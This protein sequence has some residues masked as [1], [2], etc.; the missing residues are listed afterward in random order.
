[1]TPTQQSTSDTEVECEFCDGTVDI[2]SKKAYKTPNETFS[3]QNCLAIHCYYDRKLVST[4]EGS[5]KIQPVNIIKKTGG[6][7][8]EVIES[9]WEATC[10]VCYTDYRTDDQAESTRSDLVEKVLNCC[11]V[12]EW[13][14]PE[15]Y[16]EGCSICGDNHRE[17]D[18]CT[19]LTHRDPFPE[20]SNHTYE[21]VEC[22]WEG[23]KKE[24]FDDHKGVCPECN[25]TAIKANP[26]NS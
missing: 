10:P 14:S 7:Q 18:G 19:P 4:T 9:Y 13:L 1:M 11:E 22:E 2:E 15:D 16:I 23:K 25:S 6:Q 12:T 3:H 26:I 24:D 17:S 5:F 20:P 8:D 21:C